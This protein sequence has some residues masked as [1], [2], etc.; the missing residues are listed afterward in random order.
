MATRKVR[1]NKREQR[2]TPTKNLFEILEKPQETSERESNFFI[3]K[4]TKLGHELIEQETITTEEKKTEAFL[5]IQSQT[6]T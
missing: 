5:Q 1:G 4:T 3:S 6:S 2:K